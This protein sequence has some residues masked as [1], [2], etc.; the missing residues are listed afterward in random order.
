L[1][2]ALPHGQLQHAFLRDDYLNQV[3][4]D[5]LIPFSDQYEVLPLRLGRYSTVSGFAPNLL[6]IWKW[7]QSPLSGWK[8]ATS[9]AGAQWITRFQV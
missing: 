9:P 7:N 3:Q 2:D 6:S 1:S 8:L 4:R 5:F